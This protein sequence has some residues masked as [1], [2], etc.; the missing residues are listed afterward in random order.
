MTEPIS[1]VRIIAADQ[2]AAAQ[3]KARNAFVARVAA[4]SRLGRSET[5]AVS[6]AQLETW[7]P[8]AEPLDN[9]P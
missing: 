7:W 1:H 4:T 3:T 2:V 9:Q 8:R 6:P 5:T